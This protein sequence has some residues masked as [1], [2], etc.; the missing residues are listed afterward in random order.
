MLKASSRI[1]S[2]LLMLY[3]GF[4][5]VVSDSQPIDLAGFKDVY[6]D[7]SGSSASRKDQADRIACDWLMRCL[8]EGEA[9]FNFSGGH[10]YAG[11]RGGLI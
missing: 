4:T 10:F 2:R 11:R 3:T 7:T 6:Y 9:A 5:I 1:C 8:A